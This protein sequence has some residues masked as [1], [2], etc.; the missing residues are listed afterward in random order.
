[1]DNID[2]ISAA[3]TETVK[4]GELQKVTL[5]LAEV[6]SDSIMDDGL[7]RD[8]PILG[9]IASLYKAS[10]NIQDKLF[11]KKMVYFLSNL[12]D[13]SKE[14]RKQQIE[15][16]AAEKKYRTKVGE[17]L[18]FIIDKCDDLEKSEMIGIL[19][20][21]YLEEN[22][23]YDD[24]LRGAD[25]IN[26]TCLPDLLYFITEDWS[27][28]YVDDGGSTFLSTGLMELTPIEP[29]GEIKKNRNSMSENDYKVELS[30]F[31]MLCYLTEVGKIIRR[32]LK[33]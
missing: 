14:K 15:K 30:D 20:S 31:E 28:L 26:R 5:E 32:V 3:L 24:F 12:K 6:L 33:K 16:I 2:E 21:Q 19:F 17:K 11:I 8:I 22:M 27:C 25:C 10:S 23:D 1:M 18:L 29:Q 7:L 4:D 9:T 13:I